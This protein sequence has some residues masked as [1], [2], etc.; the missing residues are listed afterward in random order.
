MAYMSQ[1][2]KK[3]KAPAI[4]AI[5]KKYNMKGSIAVRH[6]STLVVNLKS[7]DLDIIGNYLNGLA[8]D[9]YYMQNPSEKPQHI[10][11][12]TYH[13]DAHYTHNVADFLNELVDAMNCKDSD[14][15]ENYDKSDLMSDYH[16]VGWYIDINVGQWNKAYVCTGGPSFDEISDTKTKQ[17]KIKLPR[18]AEVVQIERDLWA[19][20]LTANGCF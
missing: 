9:H 10:D 16:N 1:E 11:V 6:H 3:S 14:G 19:D 20:H 2:N 12:N 8:E 18:K 17:I 15:E 13:I 4:K 5:L 7:G